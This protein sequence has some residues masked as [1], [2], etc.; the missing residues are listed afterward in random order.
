MVRVYQ[1]EW[2]FFGFK[3]PQ[4]DLGKGVKIVRGSM[5]SMVLTDSGMFTCK[6]MHYDI[7]VNHY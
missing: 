1:T 5:V 3:I 2:G 6:F 4:C 7:D